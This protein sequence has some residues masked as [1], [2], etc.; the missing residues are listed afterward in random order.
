LVIPCDALVLPSEPCEID[1]DGDDECVELLDEDGG[2]VDEELDGGV[3]EGGGVEDA[4]GC[5]ETGVTDATTGA[6]DAAGA[7]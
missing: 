7:E 5:E 4:E 2:G 6:D 1:T 3:L